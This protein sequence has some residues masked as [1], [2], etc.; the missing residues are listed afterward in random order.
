MTRKTTLSLFAAT[1]ATSGA[2]ALAAGFTAT[3]AA[4]S[5]APATATAATYDLDATHSSVIFSIKHAKVA[6][7]Y[8]RF[9]DIDGDIAWDAENP[10]SSSIALRIPVA[11]VDTGNDRRDAH[12]RNPDFFNAPEFPSIEF[13]SKKIE[14]HEDGYRVA[15]EL[16]M[17]GVTKP[18][19]VDLRQTGSAEHR[20][21]RTLIGLESTFTIKRSDFDINYG[22]ESGALGDDVDLIFSLEALAAE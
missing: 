17:H 2:L 4:P 20:S 15:G 5:T 6:K 7:F 13:T 9:N 21:G 10:E 8:G 3:P 22:L 12:L 1:V 11:S 14:S 19:T 16:S 18:L